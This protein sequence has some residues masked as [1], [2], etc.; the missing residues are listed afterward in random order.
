[1]AVESETSYVLE[2]KI[3]IQNVYTK[4]T[5]Y[6]NHFGLILVNTAMS[7]R[8]HKMSR[9]SS[10]AVELAA[11]PP[12]FLKGKSHICLAVR[13]VLRMVELY[14]HSPYISWR[15]YWLIS[16]RKNFTFYRGHTVAYLV[17][18]LCYKPEGRVFDSRWDH[19]I[20]NWPNPSSHTMALGSTQHKA[21][22]LTDIC[23]PNV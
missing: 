7:I 1:M 16:C 9:P 5:Y 21:H 18:A 12:I 8:F 6:L 20:F 15:G 10:V 23:E 4:W 22:N 14:L 13:I 2:L 11:S 17:E 3:I 19:W